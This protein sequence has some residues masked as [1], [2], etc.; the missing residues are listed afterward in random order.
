MTT[1]AAGKRHVGYFT[2]QNELVTRFFYA[3]R[4]WQR[5]E[6]L[7]WLYIVYYSNGIIYD[8]VNKDFG[9]ERMEVKTE[10]KTIAR[11]IDSIYLIM[12][13]NGNLCLRVYI[14]YL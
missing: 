9:N 11:V 1:T 14:F 10:E 6:N 4:V 2:M 3:P 13:T 8:C 5:K 7:P 12:Y